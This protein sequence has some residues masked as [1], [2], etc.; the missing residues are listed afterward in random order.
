MKPVIWK[1]IFA[2]ILLVGFT[3]LASGIPSGNAMQDEKH[4]DVDF[5]VSCLECHQETTPEIAAEWENGRHG[6]VNV[7]CFVC[8]G[9]GEV[10]FYAKPTSLNCIGCHSAN[11]VDF[12]KSE[13]TSCFSCHDGHDLKFHN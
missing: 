9:D 8:H 5:S 1:G 4:P 12:S 10:E 11:D 7:G 3:W 6:L 2:S 13:A